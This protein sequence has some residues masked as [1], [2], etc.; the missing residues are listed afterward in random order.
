MA[1]C[2][3]QRP[4]GLLRGW[5]AVRARRQLEGD[6]GELWAEQGW[7]RRVTEG[8]AE[9]V[10]PTEDCKLEWCLGSICCSFKNLTKKS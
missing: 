2:T 9:G 10:Q 5:D 4:A 7:T 3:A 8:R 1:P 6:S